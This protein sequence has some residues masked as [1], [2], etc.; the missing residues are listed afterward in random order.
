MLAIGCSLFIRSSLPWSRKLILC[1]IFGVGIF[2]ILAAVLNKYYSFSHPFSAEWTFWYVRES[3]TAIL[4]ANLPF[5][6]TLLR[7]MFKLDAFDA[8]RYGERSV[9]Y[10][11]S[12]S[13]RGRHA[14]SPR[15]SHMNSNGNTNPFNGSIIKHNS[16]G[17]SQNSSLDLSR[18]PI[19]QIT[20]KFHHTATK[21]P[22]PAHQPSWREQGV[23]GK[24]DRELMEDIEPWDFAADRGDSTLP[25]PQSSRRPSVPVIGSGRQ[26]RQSISSGASSPRRE[27][28]SSPGL[29]RIRDEEAQY[30]IQENVG[31]HFT[32]YYDGPAESD[33]EE[34]ESM[35]GAGASSHK[36]SLFEGKSLDFETSALEPT[37]AQETLTLQKPYPPVRNISDGSEGKRRSFVTRIAPPL[38]GGDR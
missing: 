25:S 33:V 38:W 22:K 32:N 24:G 15:N 10:H 36:S 3:S 5:L 11:S 19:S 17:H 35:T 30:K 2:V 20:T 9:P 18:I 29:R 14:K 27:G 13:A 7:R 12:R 4:V 1:G 21:P 31:Q 8:E 26:S 23:F 37:K 16:H 28:A 34:V 6:W